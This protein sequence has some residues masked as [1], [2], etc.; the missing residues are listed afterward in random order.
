MH[1]ST[2][3]GSLCKAFFVVLFHNYLN[4]GEQG[5]WNTPNSKYV[6]AF[7]IKMGIGM[8]FSLGNLEWDGM[9]TREF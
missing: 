9:F 5:A 7:A 2:N 1:G 3:Q 6:V 4:A 8:Q